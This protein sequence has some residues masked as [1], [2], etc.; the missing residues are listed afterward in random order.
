MCVYIYI[1]IYRY[2]PGILAAARRTPASWRP[3]RSSSRST[4]PATP[5][6]RKAPA[7]VLPGTCF[8]V[9]VHLSGFY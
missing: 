3:W 5:G 7:E 9:C 4:T 2:I 1:Y 8:C 6:R